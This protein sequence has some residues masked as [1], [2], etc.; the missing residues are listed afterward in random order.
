MHKPVSLKELVGTQIIF[1]IML[2]SCY[3]MWAGT[4]WQDWY[5]IL[6]FVLGGFLFVF[7]ILLCL[8]MEKYKKESVDELAERNLKRADSICLKIIVAAMTGIAWACVIMGHIHNFDT[9]VIGWAIVLCILALAVIRTILFVL[10]DSR[11]Q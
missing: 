5:P 1:P 7:F 8:R 2:V 6:Q 3:W 9:A 11:G 10:F 4:D